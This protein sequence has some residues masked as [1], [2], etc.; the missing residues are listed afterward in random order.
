MRIIQF[1]KLLLISALLFGSAVAAQENFRIQR[2]PADA[3]N[4]PVV[5]PQITQSFQAPPMTVSIPK[6]LTGSAGST[7][8]KSS[9]QQ[10]NRR[11]ELTEVQLK[12]LAS[13]DI[14]LMIDRSYSMGTNDCPSSSFLAD[15]LPF[16]FGVGSDNSTSRWDWCA[17]Q[18]SHMAKQTE[19]ALSNGFTVMLFSGHFDVFPH[20]NVKQLREIFAD[21]S[22]GG[23]TKLEK[24]LES[25][26][27]DYFNR[28]KSGRVKPLL[29]GVITDGCP[30]HPEFV[31]EE[32]A[33]I[34]HEMRDPNEIT[35]VFFLIGSNDR[36]GENFVWDISHNLT[37]AGAKYNIVRSVPF[38]E[39]ERM[40]LARALAENLQ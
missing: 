38:A 27:N 9:V 2:P 32:I 17:A 23:S 33:S 1:T 3:S 15:K 6:P 4:A 40:G 21:N 34:T 39:C 8:L 10:E 22:P 19:R 36:K 30:T 7:N 35:I 25:T 20:V 14:V 11:G 24:P 26:F 16:P 12:R 13:H 29:V 37:S 18:T 28:K 31:R 5:A